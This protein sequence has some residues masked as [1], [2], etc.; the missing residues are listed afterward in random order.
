MANKQIQL[1]HRSS[2]MDLELPYA[3]GIKAGFPSPAADMMEGG[4]DLNK[5]LIKHPTATFF[6]KVS[7]DSM[8]DLGIFDGDTL[9]IDKSLEAEEGKIA[10]CFVD[11]EFTLKQLHIEEDYILLMPANKN[12]QPIKVTAENDFIVWG[13]VS[14]V[15]K[16]I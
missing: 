2:E 13:I 10:V 14:Y 1:F 12:Y 4:L 8:V 6:A 5:D 3:L 11:G 16:K 7:G 15:I 9:I